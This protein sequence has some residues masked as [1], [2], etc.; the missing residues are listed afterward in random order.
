MCVFW[1]EFCLQVNEVE[2]PEGKVM[3]WFLRM[4]GMVSLRPCWPRLSSD[5][6]RKPASTFYIL[7]PHTDTL[8]H[9]CHN[10]PQA[11][12]TEMPAH[13]TLFIQSPQHQICVTIGDP[14]LKKL[15][16][17]CWQSGPAIKQEP[18]WSVKSSE[19][20]P[21]SPMMERF[22]GIVLIHSLSRRDP[23]VYTG[24]TA[25]TKGLTLPQR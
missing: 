24:E 15:L 25:C 21:R 12:C 23:W 5:L 20:W 16:G 9:S 10:G 14:R 17:R 7:Y 8:S 6:W 19:E 11:R 3:Q 18:F 1:F 22:K 13:F 2:M 4:S